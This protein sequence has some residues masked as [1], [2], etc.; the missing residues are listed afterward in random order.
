MSNPS[1]QTPGVFVKES[2]LKR[3]GLY[4]ILTLA[5]LAALIRGVTGAMT[6]GG[7]I[8]AGILFGALAAVVVFRWFWEVRHPGRLEVSTSTVR[9]VSGS[10][11]VATQEISRSAGDQLQ[12]VGRGAGRYVSLALQQPASGTTLSLGMFDR[13]P[14]RR[15]CEANGWR[16]GSAA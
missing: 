6:T 4:G 9:F 10:G 1:V 2:S 16:F 8:A 12:F 11:K 15:A 3:E 7:R 5:F 13:K 14:V